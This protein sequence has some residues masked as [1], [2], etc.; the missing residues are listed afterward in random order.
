[1]HCSLSVFWYVIHS[2][3][4]SC[5]LHRSSGIGDAD[6]KC[7]TFAK[8]AFQALGFLS[9]ITSKNSEIQTSMVQTKDI[10]LPSMTSRYMDVGETFGMQANSVGAKALIGSLMSRGG[11]WHLG[12]TEF[13]TV[14][15]C[16]QLCSASRWQSQCHLFWWSVKSL[17]WRNWIFKKAETSRKKS[18]LISC[19]RNHLQKLLL[20]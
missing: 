3:S 15:F 12:S 5:I 7:I 17:K 8:R 10:F 2:P 9:E 11:L 6:S 18:S 14:K 20:L 13:G 16:S 19:E 4:S 1:M